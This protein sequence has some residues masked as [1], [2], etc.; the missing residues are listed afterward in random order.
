[1]API[2]IESSV[3]S[4]L[5]AGGTA[6]VLWALAVRR[7]AVRHAA[8][9]AVVVSMLALPLWSVSGLSFA[10]PV[11]APTSQSTATTVATTNA[12]A[13][14]VAP[15]E[16]L[17]QRAIV[18]TSTPAI[19]RVNWSG[20]FLA[21]YG[22]GAGVLLGRLALG[23]FFAQR[24]R[25]GAGVRHGRATSDRCAAPITVGWLSPTLILPVG[26]HTWP[27][28][29]L[30]IVLAHEAAHARR[31]DPLVQGIALLNR[32]VFWFHPLAWWLERRLSTL[33]EESC[34]AAVLAAGYSAQTYSECLIDLARSVASRGHRVRAIGAA[35]PGTGLRARLRSISTRG[36]AQPMS[37]ARV[38]V[39][40]VLCAVSTALFATS[41][42]APRTAS[43]IDHL[44][45]PAA[46]HA[47]GQTTS[48][49]ASGRVDDRRYDAATVRR[50]NQPAG[51]GKLR[52][53]DTSAGHVY[54]ECGA[55][56]TFVSIA[57]APAGAYTLNGADIDRNVRGGENWT[58]DDLYTIEAK[59]AG[60]DDQRTL[61]GPMLRALLEDRFHV[62][63]HL[64]TEDVPM[65]AL[66]VAKGGLKIT[67]IGAGDCL[68]ED[69]PSPAPSAAGK[70]PCGM[71]RGQRRG[72]VRVWDL[73]GA[74]LSLLAESLDADRHV[75]DQTGTKDKFNIHLEYA[76]DEKSL[77]APTMAQALTRLG[78]SLTSTTG[79][80]QYIVIDHAE[81]PASGAPSPA[82][83]A[84]RR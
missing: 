3:R 77:D 56:A 1:M 65:Y 6:L 5:I 68:D 35:M 79:P 15:D 82:E 78:L 73:S 30:E 70:M 80:H 50:C 13:P 14:G 31:R 18:R 47:G 27:G 24:L 84:A 8:W 51:P 7:A 69:A 41:T 63:T 60:V 4:V 72:A 62:R 66:T 21:V 36:P 75:L 54:L 61:L 55:L 44:E 16:T 9:V 2:L 57:Y 17:G 10:V 28:E 26:W 64:A 40:A 34:D 83:G 11:L 25:R 59:V 19:A 81:R 32:A 46:S 22:L 76:L 20:L 23:S 42:P 67:P 53:I 43:A 37:R 39:T 52:K 49:P 48:T 58:R 74:P 45:H 38:V 29:K 71:T 33:A 12:P